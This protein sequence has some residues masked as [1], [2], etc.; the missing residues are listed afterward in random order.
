MGNQQSFSHGLLVTVEPK[1]YHALHL[2][3][4]GKGDEFDWEASERDSWFQT[5]LDYLKS[6]MRKT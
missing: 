1:D 6:V 5:A 2:D 4:G 3:D